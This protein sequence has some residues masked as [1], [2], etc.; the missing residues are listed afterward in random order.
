VAKAPS[1]SN[2]ASVLSGAHTC[3]YEESNPGVRGRRRQGKK[4]RKSSKEAKKLANGEK[5]SH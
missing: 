3:I 5:Q 1:H 2:W 4:T